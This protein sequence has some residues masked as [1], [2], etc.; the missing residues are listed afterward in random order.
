MSSTTYNAYPTMMRF[1]EDYKKY[2][3]RF[4][5]GPPGSGESVGSVIELLAVAMRQE[6]TPDGIRPTKFGIIRSTYGRLDPLNPLLL[7]LPQLLC[8]R[9]EFGV[10]LLL[11][12]YLN[13]I[14][15][16]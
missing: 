14:N 15:T 8:W 5:A 2:N 13:S 9:V 10:L 7:N 16:F 4:V 12:L 11:V 3:K 6:P 1:H